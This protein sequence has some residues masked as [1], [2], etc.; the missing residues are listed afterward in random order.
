[1]NK[2]VSPKTKDI[3]HNWHLVDVSEKTLGRIASEIAMLLMGKSKPYF[4]RHLDTGDY[5][6]V[7]NASR[8]HFTGKKRDQKQYTSYSGYPGGLRKETL[9]DLLTR[10][11]EEVIR[12]AVLGMLPKNKHRDRLIK[13]LFVFPGSEHTYTQKFIH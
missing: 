13:R 4:V 8:I 12:R 6:V 1:M 2:T 11:P 10:K 5:V 3:Q 9:R 7:V